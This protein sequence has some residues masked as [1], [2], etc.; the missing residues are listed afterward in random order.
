MK[1]LLFVAI[2]AF[3]LLALERASLVI[4]QETA[5]A[6]ADHDD[7]TNAGLG[8]AIDA[9]MHLVR[10]AQEWCRRGSAVDE[11]GA[12]MRVG[13]HMTMTE[14]QPAT[15]DDLQRARAILQRTRAALAKYQDY[16]QAEAD[17]YL[18]FMPSVPQE[19]YHF[20]NRQRTAA[21][22]LGD[23]DPALPGSLLYTKK[24]FTGWKLVGAMYDA[25]PSATPSELDERIPLGVG[26]WH[27]HTNICLPKGITEDDVISGR[28]AVPPDISSAFNPERRRDAG[29]GLRMRL[30]YLSDPRFGFAGTISDGA[31]CEAAE[32]TF[33]KQIFG[34]MIHVYPFAGDDLKVAFG[35][36]VP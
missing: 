3:A 31:E 21:E 18:P 16:R 10:V 11:M 14:V 26:R 5:G 20:A 8:T 25:P 23:F 27:A 35:T 34:W 22:Y 2:V 1:S 19:V 4:A 9:Q 36:Q 7:S 32:G 12:A 29:G 33:H 13:P 30:G 24:F 15:S 17:G 28:V 6:G